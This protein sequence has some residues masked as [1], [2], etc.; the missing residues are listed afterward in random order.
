M[1]IDTKDI[2]CTIAYLI[3]VRNDLL[4]ISYGDRSEERRVGKEC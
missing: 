2:V 3:G 4:Q 1:R